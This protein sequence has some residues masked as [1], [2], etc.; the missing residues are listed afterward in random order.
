VSA[1]TIK[2]SLDF[3]YAGIS[4]RDMGVVNVNLNKGLLE[5]QFI[6]NRTIREVSVRGNDRPYFQEIEQEPLQFEL[7]FF[8]TDGFDSDR[9]R[10]VARWLG[11]QSYY[12]PL[13]FENDPERIFYC[14]VVESPRIIHNALQQ[15]YVTLTF[16]C[17]SP[18]SYSPVYE[19]STFDY[20]NNTI[21]G[22]DYVFENQGDLPIK[23]IIYIEKVD[24]GEV[25]IVNL[26]NHGEELIIS[27]LVDG[28]NIVIDCQLETIETNFSMVNRYKDHNGVFL[29]M[30][31]G[32]NYLKIYGKCKIK[33][34]YQYILLG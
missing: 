24:Y 7:S 4:S 25:K 9:V 22:T 27:D 33:W 12:Q 21:N 5:E 11:A 3:N 23:P 10:E 15:G 31:Y 16:R 19:S 26:S 18:Y 34:K 1:I 17:D 29:E 20:S 30:V 14:L 8:F 28:E 13:Y 2:D 32:D 6:A